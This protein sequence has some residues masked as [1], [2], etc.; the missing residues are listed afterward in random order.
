MN[1]PLTRQLLPHAI[2]ILVMLVICLAY[3]YPTLE[4][5]V[6]QQSDIINWTGMA[7]EIKDYRAATGE[8]T[9]WTNSMFGGMPAYQI[10]MP[11]S[12]NWVNKLRVLLIDGLMPR[13]P[14]LIFLAMLSAYILTIVLGANSLIGIIVAIAF[15]LS[16]YNLLILEAGHVTKMMSMSTMPAVIA[17]VIMAYRRNFLGGIALT[18]FAMAC[19]IASNHYQITYYLL[20]CLGIYGIAELVRAIRQ[21]TLPHFIKVSVAL[22]LVMG[23]AVAT[24]F[25]RIITTYEYGKETTRGGSALGSDSQS[26]EKGLGRDYA[27]SWSYG[28]AETFN[29]LVPRFMGG[30][31][32]EPISKDSKIY[33][34]IQQDNGP[35]YWG[36]QPFTGG[37]TYIGAIICF[38]FV[39]GL[40]VVR[41]ELKWWLLAATMLSIMLAWGKNFPMLN[42]ILFDILPGYNK[43]RTVSMILVIAQLTIPLLAGLALY[44]IVRQLAAAQ[45]AEKDQKGVLASTQQALVRSL[46]QATAVVGGLLLVFAI[47]G[48][49]LFEF[50]GGGDEQFKQ[51]GEEAYNRLLDALIVDRQSLFRADS[52]RSLLFVLG[53][54]A[55]LW[56]LIKQKLQQTWL[57]AG[58]AFLVLIDLWTVDQRYLAA[59]SFVSRRN[60]ED[61]FVPTAADQQ[62]LQDKDPNFRVFNTTRSPFND[63]ITSY[64]HKSVGG[65]HGAKLSRYQDLIENHLTQNNMAVFN[66]LNTKYIITGNNQSNVAQRNPNALGNAWFVDSIK[67]VLDAKAE[68]AALKQFNPRT[69]AIVDQQYQ[70]KLGGLTNIQNDST[71][72]IKLTS[73]K[74][75]LLVYESNNDKE[76]LAVF[77]EIYYNDHKGWEASIDGK[78]TEHLRANYVLR[79]MKIPAGKHQIQFKFAPN[80]YAMGEKISLFSSILMLLLMVAGVAL[81]FLRKEQT[82]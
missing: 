43:F 12:S 82:A 69:T 50:T 68:N 75:N 6:L 23:L 28:V 45:S 66:M 4:G 47:L 78:P 56:A 27:F 46:L 80:S 31:S 38:L 32:S 61:A 34:L 16:T 14:A 17:G 48:T 24:D 1:N 74:P 67:V 7:K 51:Y 76:S 39:L 18:G 65:Y 26:G 13:T 54:A 71:A 30:G 33:E 15:G 20:L 64:H 41:N 53:A 11:S 57:L 35:M 62:I 79:A 58:L 10:D 3:F 22:A 63:A 73:Y 9:L 19:N 70:A 36:P 81:P 60:S 59:D 49:G 40:L 21:Q 72:S 5:K 8:N 2:A 29:L 77:S 42:N 25:T 37:P 52:F 44:E 55:L